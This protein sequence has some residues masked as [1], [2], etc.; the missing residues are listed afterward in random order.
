ML[1]DWSMERNYPTLFQKENKIVV[2][3]RVGGANTISF[4]YLAYFA[5]Q[6]VNGGGEK[7]MVPKPAR[8]PSRTPPAGEAGAEAG[9]ELHELDF[10]GVIC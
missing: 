5:K 1:Y 10:Y 7:E 3:A 2:C 4:L 9:R 6:N 8:S